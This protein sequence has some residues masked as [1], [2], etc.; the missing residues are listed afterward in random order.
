MT[1]Q[2][3]IVDEVMWAEEADGFDVETWQPPFFGEAPPQ[4]PEFEHHLP[5]AAEVAAI[6]EAAREAGYAAGFDQGMREGSERGQR[7]A[8]QET[9]ARAARELKAKVAALESIARELADP[10]SSA[11]DEIEPELLTLVT[12]LAQRVIMAELDSRGELVQGVLHQA[13]AQL[14]ARKA[15]V[16]VRVNPEDLAVV[17]AYAEDQG[18]N[19][20]WLADAEVTRGGCLVESGPSRID[21]SV[22][23]RIAQ[24]VDAIWGELIRP[25]AQEE[26]AEPDDPLAQT[27]P[28][29][30]S[31]EGLSS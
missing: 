16:R 14:P 17:E 27:P 31:S 1:A 22:E 29:Q 4:E 5:T 7:E 9:Q 3:A 12:T 25:P 13:L 28:S 15:Q 23:T 2:A 26:E 8:E 11:A 18:E 20:R 30:P 19:I 6:E 10:L 24:A 21:A